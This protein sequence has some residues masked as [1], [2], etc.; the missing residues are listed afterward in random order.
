MIPEKF[1]YP[2]LNLPPEQ[3]TEMEAAADLESIASANGSTK[4]LLSFLGAGAYDHYIPAAVDNLL[5]RGEWYT[6]YTPPISLKFLR[7]PCRRF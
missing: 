4:E 1:R 3:L 2:A 7:E 5:Q 6:A